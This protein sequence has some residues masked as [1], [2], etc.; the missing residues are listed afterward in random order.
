MINE[1]VW[2]LIG[3]FCYKTINKIN[4]LIK[5]DSY[6]KEMEEYPLYDRR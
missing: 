5:E 3:F 2:F 6:R 4:E 1:T